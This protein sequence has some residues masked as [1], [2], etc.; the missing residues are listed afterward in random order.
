MPRPTTAPLEDVR[1]SDS[2]VHMA[3]KRGVKGID[4]GDVEGLLKKGKKIRA[5]YRAL[6][7]RCDDA[8]GGETV[9]A[10][11]IRKLA[12]E[13]KTSIDEAHSDF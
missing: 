9:D 11:E 7:T 3:D 5:R 13:L 8:K 4:I 2:V 12:D 1:G 6:K 10:S